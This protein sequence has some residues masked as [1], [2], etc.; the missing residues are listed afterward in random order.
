MKENGLDG[1]GDQEPKARPA[2]GMGERLRLRR[3]ARGWSLEELAD[4]MGGLVSRQMLHKYEK[5]D[6]KPTP[7]VLV[8]LAKTLGVPS[9]HLAFASTTSVSFVAY[10]KT[11]GLNRAQQQGIEARVTLEAQDRVRLQQL[12]EQSVDLPQLSPVTSFEDAEKAAEELR[13][14]W[15]LGVDA[16]CSLSTVLE[17]HGIHI[18]E[19][20][21][22]EKFDGLSARIHDSGGETLAA[23]VIARRDLPGDQW[24]LTN[25]HELAHLVLSFA[26]D[27]TEE[28]QEKAAFRFGAAFLAPRRLMEH[29]FG[30]KRQRVS[31][32]ELFLLKPRLGMSAQALAYRL[33][34]LDIISE[35]EMGGLFEALTARGWRKVEPEPLEAEEPSWLRR[36]VYHAL[37]EGLISHEDAE[38]LLGKTLEHPFSSPRSAQS[39]LLQALKRLPLE[40][41]RRVLQERSQAVGDQFAGDTQFQKWQGASD[42]IEWASDV[43]STPGEEAR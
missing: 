29:E 5:G 19:V 16:L 32:E 22:P 35:R 28:F 7:R 36:S 1:A 20:E 21:A 27:A 41:R 34:D 38:R 33:K 13:E 39:R 4:E 26:P 3:L 9:S 12:L 2:G 30:A 15:A 37:A 14:K 6:T 11:T 8:Q 43:S 40:E 25:A 24:R 17:D 18:I 31:L 10:R 42:P 23:A